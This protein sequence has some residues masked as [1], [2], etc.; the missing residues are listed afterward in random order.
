M[1]ILTLKLG[2]K[3][4]KAAYFFKIRFKNFKDNN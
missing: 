3:P 4:L 1:S 2:N